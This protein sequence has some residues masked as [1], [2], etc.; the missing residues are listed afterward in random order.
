MEFYF[1]EKNSA[2]DE[3]I[4]IHEIFFVSGDY[5]KAGE[6]I[7]TAEGAKAVF[8]IEM[9][10]DGFVYFQ[11]KPNS[12][13][14]IGEMLFSVSNTQ[15]DQKNFEINPVIQAP[16]VKG[17]ED[18]SQRFSNAALALIKTLK[19]DI[20]IFRDFSFVTL[21]DVKNIFQPEVAE[22]KK[23]KMISEFSSVAFIGGGLAAEVLIGRL[24]ASNL[25]G[26][27]AG[28]FDSIEKPDLIGLNYFGIPSRNAVVAGYKNGD[29][30]AILI[31]VTSNIKFRKEFVE[32]AEIFDIP[33]ATYIDPQAL[34]S[35]FAIIEE[36]CVVLDSS[37]VGY[38]AHLGKNVFLSG[39]VNIDHHC[40]VGENSTF[41][42]GVYFSGNVRS[43]AGCVF[44][45]SIAVEPGLVIGDNC[46]V[47]SG[48]ILTRNVP[49]E[50]I[51]KVRNNLSFR[52]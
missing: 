5:V 48:S 20:D 32:V 31:T 42:P 2:S 10:L 22:I 30:D 39:F 26:K 44:G 1:A 11:A 43:G 47:A 23:G 41:G 34:V 8:D 13:I 36:G 29:F 3:E 17:V 16:K 14:N 21:E 38:K 19:L 7:I 37:R 45:S 18:D 40:V 12:K 4:L 46:R 49:N 28:Y 52:E 9:P 51:V 24:S 15:E 50:T 27:I 25:L 35:E 33:M 6:V